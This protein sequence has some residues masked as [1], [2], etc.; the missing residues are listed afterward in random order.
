MTFLGWDELRFTLDETE[1]LIRHKERASLKE[2]TLHGLHRKT[3]GWA[4]GLV[5][6]MLSA[7]TEKVDY[8]FLLRDAPG[9]IYD[10]LQSQVFERI[11]K[12]T[13][14][15]YLKTAFLPRMTG[16]AAEKLT[17]VKIVTESSPT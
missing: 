8:D 4:A 9:E 11:D 12:E 16:A 17:G 13:Q 1:E 7:R 14:E 2:E 15:F 10:Y 5:L 6:M 3:D